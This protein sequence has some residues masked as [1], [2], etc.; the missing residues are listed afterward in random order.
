MLILIAL[1]GLGVV[2]LAMKSP[3]VNL[4]KEGLPPNDNIPMLGTVGNPSPAMS[5]GTPV[6]S[7]VYRTAMAV[8]AGLVGTAA[9]KF[10]ALGSVRTFNAAPGVFR[11]PTQTVAEMGK[12][13]MT[14]APAQLVMPQNAPGAPNTGIRPL[15]NPI[16]L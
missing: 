4:T 6:A 15:I 9:A 3:D 12:T 5:N 13:L 2:Y 7:Q 10:T 8:N 14:Q 16:K 11:P 1:V